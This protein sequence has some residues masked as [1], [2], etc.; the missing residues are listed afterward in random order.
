MM[1]NNTT[2]LYN[3]PINIGPEMSFLL[4]FLY[5][6]SFVVPLDE[7]EKPFHP[8]SSSLIDLIPPGGTK[9]ANTNVIIRSDNSTINYSNH[10]HWH[11]YVC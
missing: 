2:T 6:H 1:N 10:Y 8:F 3:F 5:I 7:W 4:P 11:C 9:D